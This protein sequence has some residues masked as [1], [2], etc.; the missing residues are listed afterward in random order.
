MSIFTSVERASAE[1]TTEVMSLLVNTAEWLLMK[2]STQWNGL[3]KGEDSSNTPEAISRGEVYLFKKDYRVAGMV[4]LMQ[5]PSAW[6]RDLWGEVS[7]DHSA[8]YL[9]R[10]AIDRKFAGQDV[11]KHIMRWVDGAVPEQLGKHVVRLDCLASISVLNDFYR[12][13]G[14]RNV[15]EQA[16]SSGMFSKFQKNV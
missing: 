9:H 12:D 13:L 15:G 16:N 4:I 14:Y 11:G 8:I 7:G 10:L 5:E 3:L 6:D 2:G 1:N